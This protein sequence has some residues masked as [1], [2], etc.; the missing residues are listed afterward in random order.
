MAS[1]QALPLLS[2]LETHVLELHG[3]SSVI[4][5]RDLHS[6]LAP[7][8]YGEP[9]AYRIKWQ[10]DATAYILFQDA[11]VAKRA[12][13]SLLCSPPDILRVDYDGTELYDVS[14]IPCGRLHDVKYATVR[15]LN[16]PE[17]EEMLANA[18]INIHKHVKSPAPC[19]WPSPPS[20]PSKNDRLRAHRRIASSTAVPVHTND[21]SFYSLKDSHHSNGRRVMSGSMT[22]IDHSDMQL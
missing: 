9:Q 16:G 18:N 2:P 17:A 7:W 10:D 19:A 22:G 5:T 3:F 20:S 14:R 8:S 13:I 11:S 1:A 4:R 6:I 12:Y 15:P 21:S